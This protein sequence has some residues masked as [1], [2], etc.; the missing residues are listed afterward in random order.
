MWPCNLTLQWR[1][2]FNL[3][4]HNVWP[5]YN[6]M[7][8]RVND[9]VLISSSVMM[10]RI[11]VYHWENQKIHKEFQHLFKDDLIYLTDKPTPGL[12]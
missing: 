11:S 8:E 9:L 5:F 6:I 10:L 3:F 2:D 1:G 12:A 7:H 4:M